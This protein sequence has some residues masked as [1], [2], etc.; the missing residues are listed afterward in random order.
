MGNMKKLKEGFS[1]RKI[2]M[3]LVNLVCA[4]ITGIMAVLTVINK[5]NP[6]PFVLI[7]L[8]LT[9]LIIAANIVVAIFSKKE[10]D[11]MLENLRFAVGEGES[12]NT[13]NFIRS[14]L[15]PILF[16]DNKGGIIWYNDKFGEI[17]KNKSDVRKSV[18]V[19]YKTKIKNR[20]E[21]K[22]KEIISTVDIEDRSF[23]M[24]VNVIS[25]DKGVSV[26]RSFFMVYFADRTDYTALRKL[27]DDERTVVGEIIIDN[28]EEI[29]TA[30]G[31][32]VVN[33][34]IARLDN[35]FD[36]WLQGKGALIK[37][38]MRDRYIFIIEDKHLR[39]LKEEGFSILKDVR[40]INE[41]NTMPVTLS[42]GISAFGESVLD[43]FRN[44][45]A[46]MELALARGGD[47]AV[48]RIEG[49]DTYYGGSNLDIQSKNQVKA[50]L[51][52]EKLK[53]AITQSSRVVIMGH[54]N[55]DMDALGS[56]LAV[57]RVANICNVPGNIVLN[58]SNKSIDRMYRKLLEYPEY[59]EVFVNNTDILPRIDE[60]TLVVVVDTY[61]QK[62]T[63]SPKV[64][65]VASK[66]AVIDHHRKG[67]DYIKNTIFD[68]SETYVSSAS[69]L[70]TE[71]LR[72][73]DPDIR[74]PVIE[75][76][77]LYAG[78]LVDTKNFVFKTGTRTFNVAGYLREMGVDL[79]DVNQY[80]L[81]DYE[82]FASVSAVTSKAEII[83]SRIALGVVT[84]NVKDGKLVA[85]MAA[86][87][88]LEIADIGA[89][90]VLTE[91]GN[92]VA[93]SGR[94][95]GEINV[96]VILEKMGGG[97]HLTAAGA[98]IQNSTADSVKMTLVRNIEDY[99]KA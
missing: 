61:S 39:E 84:Q 82:T 51:V 48:V 38:L 58:S 62:L 74:I 87:K 32:S 56:A 2:N 85:A 75:A 68:Y 27:Y 49:K 69:E 16:L 73:V 45:E 11:E 8:V 80:F 46:A 28:Y 90:F 79:V 14:Y 31:E 6:V 54:S 36:E 91:T 57:Y 42:I 41:Q 44:A 21:L 26:E 17:F 71:V 72:N 10:E 35:K 43:N 47:Q 18:N 77:A 60:N 9:L 29:F 20:F 76:E 86:D 97:G 12:A 33:K 64:L 96:Q 5:D 50:R 63:E 88:L 1:F 37:R 66:V 13:G 3:A 53:K 7:A 59:R 55:P 30:D 15:Q 70:M 19:I 4:V 92:G 99:F 24:M 65:D 78:I 34:I 23:T 67:S 94:S 52:A 95:L 93:I 83:L 98:F 40:E 25:G 89:S 22:E 81:P